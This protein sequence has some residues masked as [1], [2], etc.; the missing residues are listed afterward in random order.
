[1]NTESEVKLPGHRKALKFL[2]LQQ[3]SAVVFT[4]SSTVFLVKV[5]ANSLRMFHQCEKSAFKIRFRSLR[6]CKSILLWHVPA[7]MAGF[8]GDESWCYAYDPETKQQSSEW[9]S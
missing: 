5:A 6:K 2:S 4:L 7:L 9:K 3:F 1:M 8:T